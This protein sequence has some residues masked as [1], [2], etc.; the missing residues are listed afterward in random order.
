[1]GPKPIQKLNSATLSSA[2][3]NTASTLSSSIKQTQ[4]PT[5]LSFKIAPAPSTASLLNKDKGTLPTIN[6]AVRTALEKLKNDQQQKY[7]LAK[8]PQ[9]TVNKILNGSSGGIQVGQFIGQN[10]VVSSSNS[11]VKLMTVNSNNMA[12]NNIPSG[13][14]KKIFIVNNAGNAVSS[15]GTLPQNSSMKFINVQGAATAQFKIK[16]A[17]S[18]ITASEIMQNSTM[19][20]PIIMVNSPNQTQS[21]KVIY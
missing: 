5:R 7:T 3:S 17:G 12:Q 13:L 19:S 10:S 2:L 11:T 1:M 21:S 18:G 4:Q 6:P 8:S 15:T 9:L 14:S 16:A 20:K